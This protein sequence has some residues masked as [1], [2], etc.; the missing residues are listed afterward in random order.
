[1]SEPKLTHREQRLLTLL[2]AA[3]VLVVYSFL[4]A[5]P[6]Q[7]SVQATQDKLETARKSAVDKSTAKQSEVNLRLA[8]AGLSRLK[9]R[10]AK[11]RLSIKERSQNWRNLES[12]LETVEDL[13]EMMVRYNLIVVSQDYQDEP[14]VSEYMLNLFREMDAGSPNS[15]PVEYWQIELQGGYNE[16]QSFL[17]AVNQEDVRTIPITLNMTASETGDGLHTWT[18]IFVV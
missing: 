5:L 17:T 6:K 9:S 4:I 3:L 16:I 8:S 14:T 10:L 11:D 7:R 18:L 15:P 1:M 12:R 2:P 13:T